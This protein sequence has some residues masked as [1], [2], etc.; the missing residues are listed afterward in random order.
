LLQD[1]NIIVLDTREAV[2]FTQG[3]IPGSVSIGLEGRF[4]EWA[5]TLLSFDKTLL[6]VCEPGK[7]KESVVRLARVGFNN[8]A[9]YLN[10]GFDAWKKAGEV[11][12]MIIDI[13]P[14][15]LAIDIPHDKSLVV[16]DVRR[17]AEFADGHV[18]GAINI[19]LAE[20]VDAGS[21][22]NLKEDQNL[23]INCRTGYRSVIAASLLK[24]QG[25][26]NL[27]NVL[28]GWEKIMLEEKIEQEKETSVL[29]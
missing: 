25:I 20:L 22:A 19:P 6:L 23:Y 1:E 4:A 8:F 12:D 27:Y 26:H 18:K 9:G 17:E 7:E 2:E 10:G 3:F 11:M 24:R 21:V 14:S 29:N 13:E 28:N 16:L 15:E 5:G